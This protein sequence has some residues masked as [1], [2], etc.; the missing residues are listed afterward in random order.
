MKHESF[1]GK[2]VYAAIALGFVSQSCLADASAPLQSEAHSFRIEQVAEGL[3]LPWAIAF[4]PDG[5]ALVSERNAGRI[6]R[7]DLDTGAIS[8]LSGGADDVY[9]DRNGGMLDVVLHPEFAG[10]RFVYYCYSAGDDALSTT[11]V[12]RARLDGDE[13]TERERI[14][15]ALPWFHNAIV[16]GCRLA[17]Q[18]DYL[19]VT[20]GDRWD[21]RHLSQSPGTHLGKVM[22]LHHDGSAPDDNPWVGLP[23]AMPEVYSLGNRNPQGLTV[24]PETGD[25]WEHEHGPKG[26]D[27]VNVIEAGKN[28]GWPMITYGTEYDGTPINGG[29]YE[30]NG[31]EQP[32]H[33]YVPSIAPSDMFFYSGDAF[34]QWR[35]NLFLGALALTHLNRLVID[36]REVV[37]EERLLED[38]G[39]RVRT[40]RQGPDGLIYIGEDTGGLYRLVPMEKE[41]D[42]NSTCCRPFVCANISAD[43]E[44]PR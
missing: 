22:R 38:R 25:L 42:P 21:L 14:F 16:Y 17:F 34:P 5:N 43:R 26:G 11:V 10:N 29:L 3:E 35:G 9:I 2:F 28:Y 23:G 41:V 19:F 6:V 1:G 15:E 30:Q 7:V 36:G 39:W 37:H 32:V 20:M 8:G 33:H 31:M 12:E 40:V 24:N 44:T 18:D 27:E 13:L 4:L